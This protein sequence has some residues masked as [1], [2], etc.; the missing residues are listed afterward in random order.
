MASTPSEAKKF[1]SASVRAGSAN[2]R[3]PSEWAAPT[4]AAPLPGRCCSAGPKK[5]NSPPTGI[6]VNVRI[7][8]GELDFFGPAEQQRPG[9]GAAFVGAAHSLGL[10]VFADPARTEADWNLFASL[11]V[12]A[13]Y[14]DIPLGVR[15][16][17]TIPDL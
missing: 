15:L 10:R 4:K 17:P 9:S 3:K 8:G 5:S 7:V 11:G 14:S 16:Q 12:D 1:Q 6:A 13:I 2:T